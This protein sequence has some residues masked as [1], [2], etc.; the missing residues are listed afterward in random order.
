MVSAAYYPRTVTV[1]VPATSANLGPGFDCLG[2]ALDLRNEIAFSPTND[3]LAKAG[4]STRYLI[5]VNGVDA[6]KVP[7]NRSNLAI[8]AAE[9]VFELVGRRP[10]EIVVRLNNRIPVGSGLGSSSSA[11]IGGLVAGN[12]LIGGHLTTEDLLQIAVEMEGHPDNVAPAMLGGLVLG[13]LPDGVHGPAQLI[14]HRWEPPRLKAIVVLPDFHLL[15][16]EARAAL[17]TA[18]D[19]SDVIFTS[20][21][22]GLLLYAMTTGEFDHLRVAMSDRIHQPYR[23]KIIPGAFDAHHAA[24]QTGAIGVALSGAGP[25]L[26]AF[27]TDNEEAIGRSMRDA[28]AA[29]GLGSRTWIL[30][31][32]ALGVDV[33][34]LPG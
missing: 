34:I 18:T 4:E 31:P 13:V 20:S 32:S 29:A 26:I 23:M 16:S 1:T 27:A 9:T 12:A 22:L 14:T 2:L 6:G 19:R 11:I 10:A 24:Y 21:R 33:S 30:N 28:F 7:T 8:I 17:P 3:T 15:T 5:S 25:S